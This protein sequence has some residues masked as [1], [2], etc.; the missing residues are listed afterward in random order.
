MHKINV[1]NLVGLEAFEGG[2]VHKKF[3]T[4]SLKS[5]TKI[6]KHLTREDMK[7]VVKLIGGELVDFKL[8]ESTEWVVSV[9][10]FKNFEIYYLLQRGEPEFEDRLLVLFSKSSLEWR[11]PAEDVSDFAILYANILVYAAKKVRKNLPK[12]SQYL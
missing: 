9:K 4:E 8:D 10:P 12:I 5:R 6:L 3:V 7:K 2:S 11:I 1:S